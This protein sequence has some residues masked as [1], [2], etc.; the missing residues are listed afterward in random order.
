M[1]LTVNY[2]VERP[3]TAV[4]ALAMP[5]AQWDQT[6]GDGVAHTF[7]KGSMKML[8]CP[9]LFRAYTQGPGPEQVASAV[10]NAPTAEAWNHF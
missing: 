5:E 1:S 7:S 8:R 10:E 2:Y 6:L 9:G 4:P 3:G